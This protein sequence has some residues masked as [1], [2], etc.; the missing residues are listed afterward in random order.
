MQASMWMS[1]LPHVWELV[2]LFN[3]GQLL[4][5][6]DPTQID[7]MAYSPPQCCPDGHAQLPPALP[8]L[9]SFAAALA[10]TVV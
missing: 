10:A 3:A 9:T 4:E 6:L 8:L 7:P 1:S 5:G 2:T